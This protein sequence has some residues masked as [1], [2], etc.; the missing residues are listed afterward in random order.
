MVQPARFQALQRE[1]EGHLFERRD[2]I[3]GLMLALLSRQHLMLA[4][5]AR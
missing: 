1:M 4:L 5:P 2:E 3:E